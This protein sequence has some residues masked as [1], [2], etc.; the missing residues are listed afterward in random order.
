MDQ[1]M[2]IITEEIQHDGKDSF[3]FHRYEPTPYPIL[4]T[5]FSAF[6]PKPDD[7]LVD[8]GCGLGRLNFYA[9]Y[10]FHVASVG[11][12]MSD[13]YYHRALANKKSFVGQKDCISFLHCR[14]EEYTVSKND[15]IFYFFN[16]FSLTI[17]RPVIRNILLS[18]EEAP[19]TITLLLYYP[20]DE[21]IFYMERHTCFQL[22][23]EIAA[24]D[25]IIRDRRER[26]L[27]YQLST[28][29]R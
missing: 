26:F 11:I 21:L 8:Y 9:A 2:H 5:I 17:F 19:R 15:T 14:A 12:E 23:D 16:P 24:S 4:D 7:I 18:Y 22:I 29:P 3:D 13:E 27:V 6:P 20:E 1:T 10:C 28:G 25:A